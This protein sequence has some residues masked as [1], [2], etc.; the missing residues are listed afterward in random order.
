MFALG[1][2][3]HFKIRRIVDIFFSKTFSQLRTVVNC[4][5]GLSEKKQQVSTCSRSGA[6]EK[7]EMRSVFT[8]ARETHACDFKVKFFIPTKRSKCNQLPLEGNRTHRKVKTYFLT[9]F[10]PCRIEKLNGGK[11]ICN[12]F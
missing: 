4:R 8:L 11:W 2:T 12:F 9:K 1:A 6:L 3:F 10:I 5:N 7:K